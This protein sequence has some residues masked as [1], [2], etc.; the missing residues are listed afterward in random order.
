MPVLNI[1]CVETHQ[2]LKLIFTLFS[3]FQ[4]HPLYKNQAAKFPTIL[5]GIECIR[6]VSTWEPEVGKIVVLNFL[7]E[8]VM[9]H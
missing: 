5:L 6:E 4:K 3:Y 7:R 9:G 8:G 1:Q 2:W